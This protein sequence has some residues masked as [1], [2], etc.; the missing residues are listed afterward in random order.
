MH[1]IISCKTKIKTNSKFFYVFL[2]IF[3]FFTLF[4]NLKLD[5]FFDF[6]AYFI[7]LA[8]FLSISPENTI[9]TPEGQL[10]LHLCPLSTVTY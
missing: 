2:F 5:L 4:L 6:L 7:H 1:T 10:D 3:N 9:A 8:K